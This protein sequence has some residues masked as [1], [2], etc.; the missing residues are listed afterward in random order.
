MGSLLQ[1]VGPQKP[2]VYWIR[3]SLVLVVIVAVVAAVWA[4]WPKGSGIP[5]APVSPSASVT[6]P[7]SP[8]PSATSSTPK[9]SPSPTGPVACDPTLMKLAVAGFEKIKVD[10]KNTAFTLS[11]TNN[12]KTACILRIS[13]KTYE[14]TVT[15]GKDRIWSTADCKKWLPAKKRTLKGGAVHE[16]EVK[17][18]LRRS[19]E[20]CKL[21][22]DQLKPGTYVAT[23][24]LSGKTSA[25]QT[26]Q[27]VR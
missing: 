23:G 6:P 17:W 9:P 24:T 22:K 15:S 1:P 27:L 7:V 13:E 25:K 14:L 21:T 12:T 10:A 5:A 20:G 3:R 8:S 2:R 26:L 11:V 16:F 19:S 18:T 4:I